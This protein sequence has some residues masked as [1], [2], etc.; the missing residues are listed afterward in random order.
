MKGMDKVMDP[1][2]TAKV[3]HEFERQSARTEMSEEMSE[4]TV[5]FCNTLAYINTYKGL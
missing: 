2:K 4:L 1:M 3:M 5:Y